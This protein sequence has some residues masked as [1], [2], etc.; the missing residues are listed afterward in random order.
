M[1]GFGLNSK[2]F[3]LL[4][5]GKTFSPYKYSNSVKLEGQ[6]QEIN[7]DLINE[8]ERFNPR[9]H[10][11]RCKTKVLYTGRSKSNHPMKYE[12]ESGVVPFLCIF[13]NILHTLYKQS[14]E[15]PLI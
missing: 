1:L 5:R 3:S 6:Y 8:R 4:F 11:Q 9:L 12:T 14:I 7:G 2:C 10:E 15:V 13:I